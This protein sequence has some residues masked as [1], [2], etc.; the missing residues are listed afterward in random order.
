[1]ICNKCGAEVSGNTKFSTKC[2]APFVREIVERN[3]KHNLTIIIVGIIVVIVILF[4]WLGILFTFTS[5]T[6]PEQPDHDTNRPI[7]VEKVDSKSYSM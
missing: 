7:S 2:G 1:M 5:S 6:G 4:V 3:K